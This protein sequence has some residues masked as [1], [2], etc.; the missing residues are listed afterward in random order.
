MESMNI[1]RE[2]EFGSGE[3]V[4]AGV[5]VDGVSAS[6]VFAV[7]DGEGDGE[8]GELLIESLGRLVLVRISACLRKEIDSS[9]VI[10]IPVR[11]LDPEIV[12]HESAKTSGN[13]LNIL[14]R[15]ENSDKAPGWAD[16]ISVYSIL[17]RRKKASILSPSFQLT[18]SRSMEISSS[19]R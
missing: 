2:V 17:P 5:E 11:D 13:L 8:E 1:A 10:W 15:K 4:V 19:E 12:L 3:T 18:L 9:R 7:L 16:F 6:R 14:A